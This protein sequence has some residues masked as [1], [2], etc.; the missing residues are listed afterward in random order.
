MTISTLSRALCL[1]AV[2]LSL[3]GQKVDYI[4][5]VQNKPSYDSRTFD[6]FR[7]SGTSIT[8]DLSTAGAGKIVTFTG[9]P[10]GLTVGSAIR[11]SAGTGTAETVLI[12]ATTCTIL[13]TT[14]GT[15]TFTTANTH[16]GSYRLETATN[17][18]QEA[19]NVAQADTDEN[20][21]GDQPSA[22]TVPCGYYT[23]YARVLI[24]GDGIGIRAEQ[25]YCVLISSTLATGNTFDFNGSTYNSISGFHIL[26]FARSSGAGIGGSSVYDLN[27]SDMLIRGMPDGI[28]IETGSIIFIRSTLIQGIRAATGRGISYNGGADIHI[29]DVKVEGDTSDPLDGGL[30]PQAGFEIISGGG[31]YI[32]NCTTLGTGK[33]L[34]VIPGAGQEATWGFVT[35]TIFD[36]SL[37]GVFLAPSSTGQVKS[38]T[39]TNSWT[40]SQFYDGV[41]ADSPTAAQLDDINFIGHRSLAN[42]LNGIHFINGRNIRISNSSLWGNSLTAAN[43]ASAI[44]IEA[45]VSHVQIV[46]NSFGPSPGGSFPSNHAFHIA[47]GGGTGNYFV[48]TGNDVSDTALTAPIA[49]SSSGTNQAIYGNVGNEGV[50]TIASATSFDIGAL[51][52]SRFNVTGTTSIT[53]ITHPWEGR[54]ISFTKTDAGS[55]SL[56][57]GGNIG[58]AATLAQFG[59]VNC[60]YIATLWYCK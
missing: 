36:T 2:A 20:P 38:W 21:S 19:V 35:N 15:V 29:T 49:F 4:Q 48:I 27:I 24:T 39:F 12:T 45:N 53:T 41:V 32:E 54:R 22:V 55:V 31:I 46:N 43:T 14:A 47:V 23:N 40:A 9:C 42:K 52:T 8:G 34:S 60:E 18:M 13:G 5:Q 33:G 37:Y 56:S 51:T 17:G 10:A 1:L 59:L 11:V 28:V 25:P 16:T 30:Q 58:S 50:A 6:W 44:Y 57:T 26:A 3:F 7:T